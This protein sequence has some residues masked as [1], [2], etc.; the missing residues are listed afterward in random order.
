[1]SMHDEI[2]QAVDSAFKSWNRTDAAQKIREC[3]SLAEAVVR[4]FRQAYLLGGLEAS[5]RLIT[6]A[7]MLYGEDL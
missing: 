3:P 6:K 4:T 5:T 7:T 2:E 1:M